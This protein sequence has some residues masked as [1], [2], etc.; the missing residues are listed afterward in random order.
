[1]W[2]RKRCD[3][4]GDRETRRSNERNFSSHVIVK[5][6]DRKVLANNTVG[7]T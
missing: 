4:K 6:G 2:F 3:I 5:G 1:M 7:N